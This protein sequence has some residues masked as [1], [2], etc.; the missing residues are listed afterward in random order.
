LVEQLLGRGGWRTANADFEIFGSTIAE[1]TVYMTVNTDFDASRPTIAELTAYIA[2]KT[3]LDVE[4]LECA[5]DGIARPPYPAPLIAAS[6]RGHTT[7]GRDGARNHP[8]C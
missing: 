4:S 6:S 8:G 3:A 2:V 1:L 7:Q 5:V